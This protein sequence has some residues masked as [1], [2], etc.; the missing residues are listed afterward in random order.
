MIVSK[1]I[2]WK[3]IIEEFFEPFLHFFYPHW[4]NEVDFDKDFEFLDKEL[5]QLFPETESIRRYTDKLVKVFTKKG[6]ERWV[7]IHIEV[8]GYHDKYFAERMFTYYYRIYDRHKKE[9]TALAIF[10]DSSPTFQ[11]SEFKLKFLNTKLTYEFDTYKLYNKKISDFHQ[12][13][14][15]PFSI[16]METAWIELHKKGH[17]DELNHKTEIARKLLRKG[18]SQ[19]VVRQL[20]NFLKHYFRLHDQ[21]KERIFEKNINKLTKTSTPM[22]LEEAILTEIKRQGL[23]A[24]REEGLKQGLEQGLEQGEQKVLIIIERLFGKGFDAQQ[25]HEITGV[26]MDLILKGMEEM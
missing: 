25:I 4:V 1:D 26:S 15:N 6:K 16:I 13:A 18:F 10:T 23:K 20:L 11:P 24:G 8:Q 12:K 5:D 14:N 17:L 3:G 2:L 7:L 21:K 9:I 19:K 22:G